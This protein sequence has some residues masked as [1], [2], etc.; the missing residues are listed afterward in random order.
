MFFRSHRQTIFGFH[1]PWCLRMHMVKCS[2]PW[3]AC[4]RDM[5]C[6]SYTGHN[7]LVSLIQPEVTSKL[8]R[9]LIPMKLLQTLQQYVLQPNMMFLKLQQKNV[10]ANS[11]TAL[12]SSLTEA[13]AELKQKSRADSR[14]QCSQETPLYPPLLLTQLCT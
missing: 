2:P 11:D 8:K 1:T 9:W 7:D 5:C 14:A 10:K 6:V 3:K 13:S 12:C 4:M